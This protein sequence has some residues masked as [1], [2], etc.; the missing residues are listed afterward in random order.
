MSLNINP[1]SLHQ[2]M[3][4]KTNADASSYEDPIDLAKDQMFTVT[5]VHDTDQQRDSGAVTSSLSVATH[6]EVTIQAGGMPFDA[7]IAMIGA[8]TVTSGAE[9][10]IDSKTGENRPYFGAIGVAPAEDGRYIAIGLHKV[11]L[12]SDPVTN[13][14]GTTNAWMVQEMSGLALA[15][16]SVSQFSRWRIYD[17]LTDWNADK[18]TDGASFLAFFA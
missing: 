5:P 10:T 18:P 7:I 8:S 4:A 11:Q 1:Y 3:I 16:A 17:A 13:A 9:V 14:D 15:K 6:G 12:Q 2:I